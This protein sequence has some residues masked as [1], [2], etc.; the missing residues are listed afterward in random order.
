MGCRTDR[1][2][3]PTKDAWTNTLDTEST[4]DWVNDPWSVPHNFTVAKLMKFG[5]QPVQTQAGVRS[6]ADNPDT[7][8]H[9]FGARLN[10][11]F[12]FPTAKLTPL[13]RCDDGRSYAPPA[14]KPGC[15]TWVQFQVARFVG[16]SA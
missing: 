13:S 4:F 11:I 14:A 1:S 3:S 10:V 15:P 5:T 9:D 7:G 2:C 8:A 6:W 16:S 12:L